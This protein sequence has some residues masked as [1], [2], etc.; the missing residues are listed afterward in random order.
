MTRSKLR[1]LMIC[2]TLLALTACGFS[3]VS[4]PSSFF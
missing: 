1:L 2:G 4:G 3:G